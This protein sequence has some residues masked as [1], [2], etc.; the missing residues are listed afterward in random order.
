MHAMPVMIGVL[1][2]FA[3]AYRYYSAFLAAR[4]AALDDA[5]ATPATRH[6]DGQNF[7]PTS[8]WVLFG[9]HFAAISG[10]GPLIGPVLAAQF[11][12]L[13]GLLWIV[14]GVCLAGAT[15][16]FIALAMSVRRDGKSL[17][18]IAFTDVGRV[19][20]GAAT[21]AI[22]LILVVALAGLGKV[23]VKALGG[24]ESKFAAGAKLVCPPEYP[25]FIYDEFGT[26]ILTDAGPKKQHI[27][28]FP[29]Q[30][31]IVSSADQS[32]TA[33]QPFDVKPK[34]GDTLTLNRE[35][36]TYT[37]PA[38]AVQL[39]PGSS[40][41]VFT[42][43]ATIPI[44]LLVGLWMYKIRPGR[45]VEASIIGAVLTLGAVF[46]G[47]TL[48]DSSFAHYFDLTQ[49]QITWAMAIYGFIAAVLPVWL[50]LAPRD[51]LSTFLK[52]GT[53]GVL[54][55]G[56]IVANPKLEAPA[57]NHSFFGGGPVLGKDSAIF[58]FLFTTIM[59][60]AISGFH[61]LVS[62]GTT[63]KMLSR[64]SHAR[65]IGY[66]AMLCEGLVGVVAL[67]A[68]ASLGPQ[69]FY[70]MNVDIAQQ[71]AWHDRITAI[72][73]GIEHLGDY[74][75][76]AQEPLRGRTG[77]AVTLAV[78]MAHIFDSAISNVGTGAESAFKKLW[79]YWYH[80][81]IMFEALFILTTIDAGSRIGRFL[82]QE[83][84]GKAV[85]KFGDRSWLPGT[86]ISTALIVA[87]WTWFMNSDNFAAIW[88]MFGIANQMLAV[89]ALAV[90]SCYLVS[91]GKKKY[92]A[93]TVLPLLWVMTTTMT[94]A[95]EM[96]AGLTDGLR[97]QWALEAAVRNHALIA[98]SLVQAIAILLMIACAFAVL[99]NAA[100]KILVPL[101]GERLG[102][103]MPREL[104]S[105]EAEAG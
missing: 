49:P 60:G 51:Y 86:I 65:T 3:I 9:H 66:G 99:I 45:T 19:A 80:F 2:L 73:G 55:V 59:C 43:A 48:K 77:G 15:Q 1:C 74:E 16:D 10:A 72:G 14:I 91:I 44:A 69:D 94:A 87:G 36:R 22:L 102:E 83:I 85:P 67:I 62:S 13:P 105:V 68:A 101:P 12:Y 95:A 7:V 38:G 25:S 78:G 20:G 70:A 104:A 52:I 28:R 63:S 58:P 92:L 6:P 64:E 41:G 17:A 90:A 30:T 53:I 34:L 89:I 5:R 26:D 33:Q 76:L 18:Q 46:V 32:L 75:T 82:L 57:L 27:Y 4:V 24:E 100:W 96:L 54:V 98:N 40:W 42:I 47:G 97:T 71:P 93:V 21:L 61:A 39:I 11:G 37:V 23:V 8:K 88:R 29:A 79:P 50:L 103:G 56:V 35:T 31:I 84:V 81:A